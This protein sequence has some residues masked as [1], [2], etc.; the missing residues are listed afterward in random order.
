MR[1]LIVLALVACGSKNK[2]GTGTGTGTGTQASC[3]QIQAH[4]TDLYKADAKAN[5]GSGTGENPDEEVADNVTMVMND[6]AAK[7]DTVAPCAQAAKTVAEL[8]Q[9]C[10]LPLDDEGSEGDRFK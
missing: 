2:E 5:V 3:A 1:W 9:R 8:E 4:V 7:P 10:L 6:C